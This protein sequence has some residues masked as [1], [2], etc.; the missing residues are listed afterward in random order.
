[1]APKLDYLRKLIA[2]RLLKNALVHHIGKVAF[3]SSCVIGRDSKKVSLAS[4][5]ISD[6][7][8]GDIL[9]IDRGAMKCPWD[10]GNPYMVSGHVVTGRGG[11][12]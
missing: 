5:E 12:S 8:S 11:P 10:C 4:V 3:I 9:H 1:M 2:S 7:I 6:L